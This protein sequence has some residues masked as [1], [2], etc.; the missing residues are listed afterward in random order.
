MYA[1]LAVRTTLSIIASGMILTGAAS[2]AD[3]SPTNVPGLAFWLDAS[4]VNDGGNPANSA[5]IGTWVDKSKSGHVNDAI[6]ANGTYQPTYVTNGICRSDQTWMP[7]VRFNTSWMTCGTVKA[8]AGNVH[9]FVVSQRAVGQLGG[10]T[11][12]RLVSTSD[13]GDSYDWQAPDWTITSAYD[14]NGN[15]LVYAA[16]VR[17]LSTSLGNLKVAGL[18]IG[19]DSTSTS[20]SRLRGDIAEVLIYTNVLAGSDLTDVVNYLNVKWLIGVAPQG[21]YVGLPSATVK[22]AHSAVLSGTLMGTNA[23][24]YTCWGTNDLGTNVVWPNY[25]IASNRLMGASLTNNLFGLTQQTTYYCRFLATNTVTHEANWSA[26]Y[27]FKTRGPMGAIRWDAWIGQGYGVGAAVNKSLGPE[28]WHYRVPYFGIEISPTQVLVAST[29]QADADR[30]IALAKAAGL[31]YWAYC[32]YS[33][34]DPMTK[35]GIDLHLSS[36][37]RN[38][39]KFC[40]INQGDGPLTWTNY[41]TRMLEYFQKTNHVT[42]LGGRPLFYMLDGSGYVGTNASQWAT[43]NA[44][45][46]AFNQLRV[47]A[48]N[49]G[50]QNPYL[51]YMYGDAATA[52]SRKTSLGFDAI[53]SYAWS[54]NH[55]AAPYSTLAGLVQGNWNSYRGTGSQVV[56]LAMIG[57]DRRPR[58]ENPVPWETWQVPGDGIDKYYAAPTANEWSTHLQAAIDWVHT[59]PATCPA[60]TVIIYAWNEIDEGGWMLPDRTLKTMKLEATRDVLDADHDQDGDG[61]DDIWEL[62]HFPA[63]TNVSESSDADADGFQDWKECRAGTDPTNSA[64]FLSIDQVSISGDYADVVTWSSVSGISY[65]VLSSTNLVGGEWRTNISGLRAASSLSSATADVDTA[66]VFYRIGVE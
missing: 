41:M 3:F 6:Q 28:H 42:V 54:G 16:D 40:M 30:Q 21:P 58:V 57:W 36:A 55:S 66:S 9:A 46:A 12:P 65:R 60:D 2:A 39:M 23:D 45:G 27:S 50:L 8:T 49:S 32:M 62:W 64:S 18:K 7:V 44:Y 35:F 43:W 4:D 26:V 17:Q 19:G 38:D 31:D 56:P 48:T 11:Y 14:G 47:L 59:Y 29:T 51:V 34:N 5:A 52:H 22:G 33:T 10:D 20:Q 25:Q 37:H 1:K 13:G 61:A 24:V 15:A 53:S 63:L